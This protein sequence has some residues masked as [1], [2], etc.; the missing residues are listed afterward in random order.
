M[1]DTT[2]T[3][4]PEAAPDDKEKALEKL[5]QENKTKTFLALP[6][7]AFEPT[8]YAELR[9]LALDL[10]KSNLVPKDMQN[11]PANIIIALMFGREIGISTAQSLTSIMVVNGRPT[12]WGDV[13]MGKVEA[14]G[15]IESWVD[16]WDEA[17]KQSTFT[18]KR[19]GRQP[20][21]RT[22]SFDDAKAA[23]LLGKAGPWSGYPKR[24]CFHR[25]RSWALRDVFP[26]IL[27]GIRIYEEERDVVEMERTARGTYEP[28][29]ASATSPDPIPATAEAGKETPAGDLDGSTPK[30][31]TFLPVKVQRSGN[32]Y[33]IVAPDDKTYETEHEAVRDLVLQAIKDKAE[34]TVTFLT[35]IATN[36]VLTVALAA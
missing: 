30:T 24:M 2:T 29:R 12:L 31:V 27:K 25:A 5:D 17:K 28:R 19:K 22:F 11:Q 34:I 3:A 6:N 33:R 16:E 15:Q 23:G 7:H 20:V 14:S 8:N 26:D 36:D 4:P 9:T 32:R 1:R 13:V 35:G 21:T 18:I 10:A